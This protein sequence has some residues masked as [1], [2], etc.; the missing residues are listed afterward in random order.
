MQSIL[1][2]PIGRYLERKKKKHPNYLSPPPRKSPKN[3]KVG[4]NKIDSAVKM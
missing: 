1:D 2:K 3:L 4:R